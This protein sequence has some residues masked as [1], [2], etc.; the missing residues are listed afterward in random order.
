MRDIDKVVFTKA[1]RTYSEKHK[2]DLIVVPVIMGVFIWVIIDFISGFMVFT[3]F[4]VFFFVLTLLNSEFDG[5]SITDTGIELQK[6]EFPD[7][8]TKE[9]IPF[10]AIQLLHYGVS[11]PFS[12]RDANAI[13]LYTPSGALYWR[14]AINEYVFASTLLYFQHKNVK[15]KLTFRDYEIE[16]YLKGNIQSIPVKNDESQP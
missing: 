16:Q 15:I 13:K 11:A 1:P 2:W 7:V 5:W 6:F 3:L 8:L 10:E 9:F 14:V 4:G 12:N